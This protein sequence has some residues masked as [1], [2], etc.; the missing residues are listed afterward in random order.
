MGISQS[1]GPAKPL[2]W[3]FYACLVLKSAFRN[4]EPFIINSAW[5]TRHFLLFLPKQLNKTGYW[6]TRIH[7]H[8]HTHE[9]RESCLVYF[10]PMVLAQCGQNF[11][12]CV[13]RAYFPKRRMDQSTGFPLFSFPP[14]FLFSFLF[15]VI[16]IFVNEKREFRERVLPMSQSLVSGDRMHTTATFFSSDP[17]LHPGP[18]SLLPSDIC[19]K[20]KAKPFFSDWNRACSECECPRAEQCLS[21]E[22][23]GLESLWP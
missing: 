15:I 18:V 8:T 17:H 9:E 13:A 10:L 21:A 19:S 4:R 22:T 23:P 16:Q 14:P 6:P 11:L 20:C 12:V 7:S 5:C 3:N 2:K 1:H